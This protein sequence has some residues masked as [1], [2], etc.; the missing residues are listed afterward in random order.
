MLGIDPGLSRCGYGAVRRAGGRW[1]VAAGG[2]V[3][4]D[5]QSSLPARLAALHRE[6]RSLLAELRPEAVAVERVF[7]QTN[8]RT[9]M[10]TGQA[11]GVALLAAAEAGAEIAQYTPNEV[12][13]AV[14]GDGAADKRQVQ[15]M[16]AA[17]LGLPTVP[18]PPDVADA[19]ALAV[20]H[21]TAGSVDRALAASR[22]ASQPARLSV[23]RPA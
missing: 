22:S 23:R 2:V 8:A 13:M 16:V 11:S 6:L 17:V 21:A 3:L 14:C 12:K 1:Q 18:R 4:T 10:A 19:L 5:R 9:A 15:T 20:C 7:F